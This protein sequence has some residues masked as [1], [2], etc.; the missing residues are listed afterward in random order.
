MRIIGEWV[1]REGSPLVDERSSFLG[2]EDE[3]HVFSEKSEEGYSDTRTVL[4]SR[5]RVSI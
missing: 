1:R 3:G 5:V 2:W 4:S